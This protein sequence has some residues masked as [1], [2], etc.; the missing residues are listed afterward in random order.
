MADLFDIL[1]PLPMPAGTNAAEIARAVIRDLQLRQ[2]MADLGLLNLGAGLD[3]QLRV[4]R[5]CAA[6]APAIERLHRLSQ[7]RLGRF[8]IE[9]GYAHEHRTL[10]TALLLLIKDGFDYWGGV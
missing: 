2:T 9:A 4:A 5:I 3:T 8:V 7:H 6:A 10:E 1:T